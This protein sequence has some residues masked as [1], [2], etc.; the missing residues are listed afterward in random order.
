MKVFDFAIK[1]LSLCSVSPC[2]TFS[3]PLF[4]MVSL[5][6]QVDKWTWAQEATCSTTLS[7]PIVQFCQNLFSWRL[8]NLQLPRYPASRW[9]RRPW[10]VIAMLAMSPLS[11]GL[12]PGPTCSLHATWQPWEPLTLAS[13]RR[14][15]TRT[16]PVMADLAVVWRAPRA[17][18]PLH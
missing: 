9:Q 4:P 1:C 2:L 8:P 5:L 16:G 3:I 15:P 18:T 11:P 14:S 13:H 7:K 12:Q 17:R 10:R 6:C